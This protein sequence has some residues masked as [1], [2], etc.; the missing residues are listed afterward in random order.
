VRRTVILVLSFL[1]CYCLFRHMTLATTLMLGA[2]MACAYAISVTPP[3]YLLGARY[4][5]V[6]LSLLLCPALIVYPW[7]ESS[8]MIAAA[9][10]FFAFYAI[11]LF[12]VTTEEKGRQAYKEVTGLSLLWAA[13]S[14][15]LFLTGLPEIILPL[16]LSVVLFLFI[17]NRVRIIPFIAGYTAAAMVFLAVK[18]VAV[19]G[20]AMA[21]HDAVRYVLLACAFA[22]L[23]MTFTAFLKRSDLVSLLAFFGLLYVSCDLLMSLGFRLKGVLLYQPV[24]A[25]FIIG[26]LVGMAMKGGKERP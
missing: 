11:A 14:L 3:K 20:P 22:L 2:V 15:N 6:G 24:L 8:R 1:F 25:L 23:V 13:S 16:S 19:L 9:A 17:I 12:L 21:M 7:L 10:V 26:P 5:L 4:P 18:G